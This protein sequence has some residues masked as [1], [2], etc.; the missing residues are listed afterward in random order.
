MR[1][2]HGAYT[3]LKGDPNLGGNLP[4]GRL[5]TGILNNYHMEYEG[6]ARGVA[7]GKKSSQKP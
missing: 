2:D 4:H 6:I 3:S 5:G 7:C 1:R